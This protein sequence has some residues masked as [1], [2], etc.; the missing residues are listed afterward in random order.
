MQTMTQIDISGHRLYLHASGERQPGRPAVI[1]EAGHSDWSHCWL[2]VQPD[3]ARFARVISYDRAGFGW[4]ETGPRPRTPLRLVTELHDLLERAGET[5]PYLFVG[6]SLG[7]ALGR[8]FAGLYPQEVHG[9]V[10]VDSAHEQ[11]QRYI[12]F[13]PAVYHALVSAGSMGAAL[14]HTGLV[15]RFGRGLMLANTPLARTP[16][17]KAVVVTQMGSP[18]FFETMRDETR[19]WLPPENW[20]RSPRMLGD[21]P[22]VMIEAQYPAGAPVPCPPGIWR[23][24]RAGWSRIQDDLARLST[25]TRRV[26]VMS[27]HNVMYEHPEVIIHAVREVFKMIT[28]TD[29][30]G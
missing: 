30:H 9:M 14:A 23:E 12:S 24:Y 13:W 16:E 4:S 5:G 26:P 7:A 6:H 11:M 21:L 15:R 20:E 22:V 8:L 29:E 19:G 27:A 3:I 1:L 25:R 10:W 18:R 28:S 17:E 2:S